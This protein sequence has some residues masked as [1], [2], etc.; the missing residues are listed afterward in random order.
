MYLRESDNFL[1]IKCISPPLSHCSVT[2]EVLGLL[3]TA[4]PKCPL[5]LLPLLC[6]AQAHKKPV[7][8]SLMRV[9]PLCGSS[10]S[11]THSPLAGRGRSGSCCWCLAG[12]GKPRTEIP[13]S[14]WPRRPDVHRYRGN[15]PVSAVLV[16]PSCKTNTWF[17][18]L[19]WAERPCGAGCRS[20]GQEWGWRRQN[21]LLLGQG[22]FPT[23][24]PLESYRA[25]LEKP[26]PAEKRRYKMMD[27]QTIYVF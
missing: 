13:A 24:A 21:V 12:C 4:E 23:P 2:P 6:P 17:S 5:L 18:Q 1:F 15:S 20:R 9:C 22:S 11:T 27:T 19:A 26:E 3:G 16:I 7:S 25:G 8:F 14:R 10:H